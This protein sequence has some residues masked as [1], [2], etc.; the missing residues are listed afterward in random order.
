MEFYIGGNYNTKEL[1][2]VNKNIY[3]E[4]EKAFKELN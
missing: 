4:F 3:L 2:Q 1:Y